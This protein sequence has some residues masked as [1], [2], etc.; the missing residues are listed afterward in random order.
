MATAMIE[1]QRDAMRLVNV[2]LLAAVEAAEWAAVHNLAQQLQEIAQRGL[3][4]ASQARL[5]DIAKVAMG[6]HRETEPR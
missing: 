3:Y 1:V 2:R 6:N 5:Q 4:H